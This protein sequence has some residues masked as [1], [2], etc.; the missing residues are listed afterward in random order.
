MKS[1]QAFL[2]SAFVLTAGPASAQLAS[3]TA[4]TS[5]AANAAAP[6]VLVDGK[7][8]GSAEAWA[9]RPTGNYDL[10]I[11]TP[12]EMLSGHLALADSAGKLAA[13]VTIDGQGR[14]WFE[15]TVSG[16]ELTLVM[17]RERAPITMHLFHRGGRVS[18]TWTVGH[19]AGT[20]EGAVATAAPAPPA[21]VV[22]GPAEAWSAK[23]IGKFRITLTIPGH[24]MT[25]DVIVREESGKVIANIW[26][27]GDG[28]GRDF[29]A[30]L[31]GTQL[32]ISGPTEHGALNLTLEHRGSQI[33][34]TWQLGEQKGPVSGD[35]VK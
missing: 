7:P 20:L 31:N 9:A 2:L 32:V 6:T 8:I 15:P 33:T 18:G 12:G 5:V 4:A 25:A 13:S 21:P 1:S 16:N 24:D 26:P 23:G 10:T 35:I 11:V 28:D 30:A 19:D 34:G 29:D 3:N 27:V 17:K 22:T 14:M